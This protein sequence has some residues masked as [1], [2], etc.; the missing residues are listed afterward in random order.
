MSISYSGFLLFE[1]QTM[2][3]LRQL[4]TFYST[5]MFKD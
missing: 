3:K 4:L 1:V 5:Q 2:E